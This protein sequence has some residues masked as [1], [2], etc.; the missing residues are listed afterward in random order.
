MYSKIKIAILYQ[1]IMHYRIP[2]YE[3]IANDEKYDM[4]LFYGKGKKGTKLINNDIFETRIKGK[5][6]F[7]IRLPFITN[8]R[9]GT[10]LLSPFLFF[11]LIFSSPQ[12]IFSEGS[13][14]LLNASIAF[15][16]SKLFKKK[17]IWWSLGNLATTNYAGIRKFINKWEHVIEKK[18]DAIF[19]YS[20]QGKNYFI[21]RGIN[22]KKIFVAVN[23]IDTNRKL[24]EIEKYKNLKIDFAFEKYFNLVF[25]GSITKEKN[26]EL[27][28]DT[29]D[30]F[31]KRNNKSG[32]LHIVGDGTY[33][34]TIE[35]YIQNKG[36]IDNICLYGRINEGA[37][38]ILK[39]CDVM[40]LPGLG[41]LAIC[42]AMLNS[43]PVITGRA[44]GTEIDLVDN[45]NGF[46]LAEMTVKSLLSKIEYLHNNSEERLNMGKSS[47]EKITTIYNFNNYYDIFDK[48][49]KFAI[50]NES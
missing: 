38:K 28:I 49:V 11:T 25:I 8:N 30:E 16:Y 21:S 4:T 20:T 36:M 48:C 15:I 13:S 45:S 9:S 7:S 44:D 34:T 18:S 41:G 47:Y 39:Y 29:L 37:N 10:M 35:K 19:T 46:I 14:S 2:F 5:K 3:R 12:V 17:F 1:V 6:L 40:I 26:L 27:L 24:E 42:E 32:F 31:N 50:N 22:E 33:M 23:V 43:L